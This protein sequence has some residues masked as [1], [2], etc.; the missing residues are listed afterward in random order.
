MASEERR[1]ATAGRTDLFDQVGC[2]SLLTF[3]LF[4]S[5][6]TYTRFVSSS[7]ASFQCRPLSQHRN[8]CYHSMRLSYF[9]RGTLE[10]RSCSG[11][12]LGRSTIEIE[13]EDVRSDGCMN[14]QAATSFVVGGVD[15]RW[16]T[17]TDPR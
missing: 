9:A 1:R 13:F 17:W 16:R 2:S 14:D 3:V 12:G 5:P 11:P 4:S 6:L 10:C 15:I 7:S 8:A